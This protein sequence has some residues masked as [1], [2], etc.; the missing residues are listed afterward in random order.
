MVD[1]VFRGRSIRRALGGSKKISGS[2]EILE[3][4]RCLARLVTHASHFD[5]ALHRFVGAGRMPLSPLIIAL[6]R[7]AESAIQAG[8][9]VDA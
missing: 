3:I 4:Q 8:R 5:A 9:R 2:F 7:S 1:G 6:G